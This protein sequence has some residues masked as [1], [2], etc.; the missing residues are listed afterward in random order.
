M[1]LTPNRRLLLILGGL[2]LAITTPVFGAWLYIHH[3]GYI[4]IRVQENYGH[5]TDVQ[6]RIPAA[7]VQAGLPLL[8]KIRCGD[9]RREMEQNARLVRRVLREV[10]DMPDANLVTVRSDDEHVR[11]TKQGRMLEIQVEGD[12]DSVHL[13]VPIGVVR[14][15]AKQI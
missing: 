9:D 4:D 13:T 1:N 5:G 6:M 10:A 8:P 11:I 3:S 7:L 2:A 15:L 12:G 14:A